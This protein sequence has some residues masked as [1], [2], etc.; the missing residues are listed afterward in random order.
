MLDFDKLF[1]F[2]SKQEIGVFSDKDCAK[3]ILSVRFK[4]D[5]NTDLKR[6]AY[7]KMCGENCGQIMP[8]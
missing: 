8:Q 1:T 4:R 5:S 2:T 6:L 3:I 7:G